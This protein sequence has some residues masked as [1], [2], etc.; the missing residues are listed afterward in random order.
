M[1]QLI[2]G[3]IAASVVDKIGRRPLFLTATCGTFL[4]SLLMMAN[5]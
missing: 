2:V 1:S 3:V 5:R 4:D